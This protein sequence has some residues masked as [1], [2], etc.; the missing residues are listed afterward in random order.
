MNNSSNPYQPPSEERHFVPWWQALKLFLFGSSSGRVVNFQQGDLVFCEGIAFFIDETESEILYAASASSDLSDRRLNLLVAETIRVLPHFVAA[1]PDLI[2]F[3]SGRKLVIR[4][5]NSYPDSQTDFLR[6]ISLD[7][8]F[9]AAI[10][11]DA[12]VDEETDDPDESA[13]SKFPID[14]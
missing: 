10:L 14:R 6:E 7:W 2:E 4:V 5:V 3:L 9:L 1:N 12:D 13:E 11:S 8:D